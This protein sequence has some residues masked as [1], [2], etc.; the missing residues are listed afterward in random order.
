MTIQPNKWIAT[1]EE[2]MAREALFLLGYSCESKPLPTKYNPNGWMHTVYKMSDGQV[3]VA[4]VDPSV[5]IT[6]AATRTVRMIEEY[7]V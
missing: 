1:Q 4:S 7:T 5:F 3:V 2:Q 6:L